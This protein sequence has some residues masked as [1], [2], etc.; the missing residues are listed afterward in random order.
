MGE[1]P[2]PR[3]T[4]TTDVQQLVAD[5]VELTGAAPP[6]LLDADAPVYTAEETTD[7]TYLVGLIGGKD[8]GKSS[9]V[10]ALAGQQI[11]QETSFGEGTHSVIA[12]AHRAAADELRQ[13]LEREVPGRYRIVTHNVG[14]LRRQ[15]L[16]DLPDIDSH[17]AGHV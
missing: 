4:M 5:A 13:L 8:V 6:E 12:Y 16:L 11:S 2:M 14:S 15:V 1:A 10:N 9:L 17:W 7:S 3:A